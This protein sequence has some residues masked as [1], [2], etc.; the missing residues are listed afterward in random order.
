ML[1]QVGVGREVLVAEEDLSRPRQRELRR[2]QFLHLDDHVRPGVD[3]GGARRDARTGGGVVGVG[4]TDA[5]AGIRF[6]E[7]FMAGQSQSRAPRR[8][9]GRRGIRG[10]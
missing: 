10:S 9:S 7:D 3:L 4:E 1:Q 6:D 2:L 8:A 5:R